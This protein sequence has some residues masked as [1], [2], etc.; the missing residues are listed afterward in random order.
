MYKIE[1]QQGKGQWGIVT[2]HADESQ[3]KRMARLLSVENNTPHRV[4]AVDETTHAETPLI[5]YDWGK[6]FIET[7]GVQTFVPVYYES[8]TQEDEAD[9]PLVFYAIQSRLNPV[10]N[11]RRYTPW[12]RYNTRQFVEY[13]EAEHSATALSIEHPELDF[14]VVYADR[15]AIPSIAFRGG[16]K[17]A[18]LGDAPVA[19]S[20][21]GD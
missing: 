11:E 9:T 18:Q 10:L 12:S 13:E 19:P 15:H 4:V 6:A 17:Y 8:L 5:A 14:R 2:Q 1:A 3:A 16:V 7:G 20:E 21:T